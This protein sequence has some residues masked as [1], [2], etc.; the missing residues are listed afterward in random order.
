M[1][2]LHSIISKENMLYKNEITYQNREKKEWFQIAYRMRNSDSILSTSTST[3]SAALRFEFCLM[4]VAFFTVKI[5]CDNEEKI[6]TTD[7][8]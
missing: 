2:V 6:F 3:I 1:I 8:N 7:A 4:Y 5:D